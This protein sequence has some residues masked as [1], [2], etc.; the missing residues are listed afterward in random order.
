MRARIFSHL[1]LKVLSIALATLIWGLVA[2]QRE[3][4]RS[5]R[6]PLEYRNLPDQLEL[7]GEPASVVDVRLRGTSGALGELQGTDLVAVLNLEG[8][9]PGRRLFHILPGDVSVPMGVKVLQ[10]APATLSLTFEISAVRTVPIVPD[11]DDEPAPGYEVGRV[12]A[13]P[14]TVDVSGPASAVR[15]VTEA[16]TEPI[17]IRGATS[18]VV[19]TITVG[20]PD[21]AVRLRNQRSAVVT[22][23]I[24]P[25]P[26]ERVV[27]HVPVELRHASAPLNPSASPA[28]VTVRLRGSS[29]AVAALRAQDLK[30]YADLSGLGRGRYNLPVRFDPPRDMTITH[31]EP[32]ELDV[33]I[34]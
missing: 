11:I 14:P 19:D 24:R 16:T 33:R 27:D 21:A 9:R 15:G 28:E 23:E 26:I 31:V 30:V 13:D 5:L 4:E 20:V 18:S 7:L 3:A 12:T 6:V 29:S 34:R 17:S 2:G 8:A 1:G 10:I 32:P 22:V 25:V